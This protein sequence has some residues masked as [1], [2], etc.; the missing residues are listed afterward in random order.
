MQEEFAVGSEALK[1]TRH[2]ALKDLFKR[3]EERYPFILC[4]PK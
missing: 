3:D 4:Y 1:A 2:A